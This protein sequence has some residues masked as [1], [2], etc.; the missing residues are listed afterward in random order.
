MRAVGVFLFLVG[1]ARLPVS[2]EGD[3]TPQVQHRA[4]SILYT[5]IFI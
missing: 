4:M 2:R 3:S 1:Q 5:V